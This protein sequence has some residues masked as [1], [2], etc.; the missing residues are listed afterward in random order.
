V[1]AHTFGY[2]RVSAR[3][4]DLS[5]QIH[6]I[7]EYVSTKGDLPPLFAHQGARPD[8]CDPIHPWLFLEKFTGKTRERVA[9]RAVCSLLRSGDALIVDSIDRLGRDAREVLNTAH[10]LKENDVRLI[11]I[12]GPMPLDLGDDSVQTRMALLM[13]ATWAEMELIFKEERVASARIAREAK[14][15]GMG[16]TP[17]L[18]PEKKRRLLRDLAAGDSIK[19]VCK[20][21]GIS[22][23]TLYRIKAESDGETTLQ[24]A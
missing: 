19:E 17:K 2:G 7:T 24:K 13:L 9:F 14:G 3:D 8:Y 4:Q 20:E 16:R 22:R 11:V 23:A 18:S 1:P 12:G 10:E 21:Y 5:R 6:A 15:L